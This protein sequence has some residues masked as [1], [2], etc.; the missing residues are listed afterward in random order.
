LTLFKKFY[1]LKQ[2]KIAKAYHLTLIEPMKRA[3]EIE[4]MIKKTLLSFSPV[5]R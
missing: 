3:I 4:Q 2:N 1:I 5:L